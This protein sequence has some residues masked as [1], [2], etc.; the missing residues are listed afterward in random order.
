MFVVNYNLHGFNHFTQISFRGWGAQGFPP[1]PRSVCIE[2]STK[3]N[4]V[5]IPA[6]S[7]VL[8]AIIC[9]VIIFTLCEDEC[10]WFVVAAD[11]VSVNVVG[12][13]HPRLG[14]QNNTCLIVTHHIL[15]TVLGEIT[16][17]PAG[18]GRGDVEETCITECESY[19]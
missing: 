14:L 2:H 16:T 15:V 5:L 4:P 9:L 8:P 11:I 6:T 7:V 17:Q 18:R 3:S 19:M 1:S 12:A 13:F 10:L